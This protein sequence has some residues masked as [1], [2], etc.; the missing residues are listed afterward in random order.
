MRIFELPYYL[1]LTAKQYLSFRHRRRLPCKVISIGNITVGGT[2]K[3]PATIAVAEEALKRGLH[4]VILTRGYKGRAKGPCFVTKGDVP[5]LSVEDAGD[6]SLLMA[7]RLKNVAIV[8]GNNRYEAGMF[9]LKSLCRAKE[10]PDSGFQLPNLFILDDGFQH[11]GLY[12]DKD[13]VLIDT[14][15]PFGNGLLLPFG[16]LREPVG[17]LYRAD[18][19]VLTKA[20][21]YTPGHNSHESRD[22]GLLEEIKRHNAKSRIFSARHVPAACR[23]L[24]GER[25]SVGWIEGKKIY[26]FCALGAPE[27]FK[28]TIQSL[29][30]ELVGYKAFRDH[31]RYSDADISDIQREAARSNAEWIVTTEKDIIK[32][33]NLDV[34]KNILFI[35]IDFLVQGNFFEAVFGL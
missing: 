28:R 27:S 33:R 23:L 22:D 15:N 6:E 13:I 29:G 5:L 31:H 34:P 25:N 12:R 17:S 24:S 1:G 18:I 2:G 8:K 30:G 4:P 19:I 10:A 9:A 11:Q 16:R 26:G 7:E 14:G 35:E 21:V 3:T 20:E 32:I